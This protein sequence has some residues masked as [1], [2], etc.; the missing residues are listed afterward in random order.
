M[1]ALFWGD[2]DGRR[3]FSSYFGKYDGVWTHG[4]F[5]LVHPVTKQVLML[6]RADGVLDPSGVRFGSSD[7]YNVIELSF[8]DVISDGIHAGQRR[9]QDDDERVMLFLL[10]Q[11]GNMFSSSLVRQVQETIRRQ[12]SPRHVPSYVFETPEI[13][14]ST[15]RTSRHSRSSTERPRRP[16]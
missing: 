10:M 14:V 12:L 4:D 11:P 7:I 2:I 5:I 15:S 1:P 3:F 13:P 8:R 16:Q 9:P 6:G